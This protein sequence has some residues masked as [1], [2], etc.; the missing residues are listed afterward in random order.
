MEKK[1]GWKEKVLTKKGISLLSQIAI[2]VLVFC[3]Y[4]LGDY[5]SFKG[6]IEFVKDPI[7]WTTTTISLILIVSLMI[8]IRAMRKDKRIDESKDIAN[9]MKTVQAV[10]KVVLINAYDK[11]F[12]DYIDKVNEDYKYETYINKITKK[13]NKL[14]LLLLPAEKKDAKLRKYEELLRKPREEVLKMHIR[15][16]KITQTGLFTGVDG[17]LA[18]MSRHDIN[19]HESKDIAS[20]VGY[21]AL[22]VYILTTFSGTLVVNFFFSGWSALWGTLL[23]IFSIALASSSAMRQADNFVDYNIEQALDNRLRIILGFV[24]SSEE[25]KAKVLEKLREEQKENKIENS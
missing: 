4:I 25:I 8:T 14:N 20:M 23:K 2:I 12:Q 24:N 3:L 7:Y 22:I 5:L 10:R 19:T 18:V 21:K 6:T 17:K 15:F 16:K 1:S 11:E 13:I 9:N